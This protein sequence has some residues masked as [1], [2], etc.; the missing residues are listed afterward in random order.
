MDQMTTGNLTPARLTPPG[1]ILKEELYERGWTQRDLA[2]ILGR[3]EQMVSEIANGSKQITPETSIEL[4]QAFGTSPD[5]WFNLESNYRLE[6]ARRV[7][8]DDSIARRGRL[9]S[10][11]PLREMARRGWLRWSSSADELEGEV[12]RFFGVLSLAAVPEAAAWLR[13]PPSDTA[14]LYA[15]FAWVRRLI[16]L[17]GLPPDPRWP[18]FPSPQGMSLAEG[19]PCYAAATPE[20][21]ESSRLDACVADLLRL[22]AAAE[23]VARVP[24]VLARFGV[25]F[26]L[27]RSLQR[28][29]LDGA[30][31]CVGR[32][33]VAALTLRRD[34][35]DAF[36]FTLLHLL[37]HLGEGENAAYLDVLEEAGDGELTGAA[38]GWANQP[39]EQA[40]NARAMD[41]LIGRAD[42]Q[43]T[44]SAVDRISASRVRAYAAEKGRHPGIV[45]GCLHHAGLLAPGRL[46][47]AC[48]PISPYLRDY[49]LD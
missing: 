4:A 46:L 18:P 21:W 16:A 29:R 5:F 10:L 23:G 44:F 30:A 47:G 11:F 25:R 7:P 9:M 43:T 24:E 38:T 28:T 39:A 19:R 26:L 37:A 13:T 27:L 22:S 32:Q 33:A 45:V 1:Q 42:L 49:L 6:L 14:G 8:R 12:C 20:D 35:I 15:A 34:R 2:A 17:A 48:V 41:W 3:P 36:W 40:A 31:W